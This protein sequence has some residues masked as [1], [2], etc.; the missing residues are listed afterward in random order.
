MCSAGPIA[1][2]IGVSTPDAASERPF[3]R[4]DSSSVFDELEDELEPPI[5][6]DPISPGR[7]HAMTVKSPSRG[8]ITAS[9]PSAMYGGPATAWNGLP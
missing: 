2:F 5:R 7:T 1:T 8:S 3:R 9:S 4:S 6:T